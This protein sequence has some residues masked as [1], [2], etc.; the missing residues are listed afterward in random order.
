MTKIFALALALG[1]WFPASAADAPAITSDSVLAQIGRD[2]PARTLEALVDSEAMD[3][4]VWG[5]SSGDIQWLRVAAALRPV[6][7]PNI[8]LALDYAVGHAILVAPTDVLRFFNSGFTAEHIC[9]LPFWEPEPETARRYV[10]EATA[11]LTS[12]TD[13]SLKVIA[14]ECIASI[15]AHGKLNY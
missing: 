7:K 10:Q 5:T 4:V 15:R 1:V 14:A 9:T 3:S 13:P 2:G 12:V 6:A 11:A 8:D